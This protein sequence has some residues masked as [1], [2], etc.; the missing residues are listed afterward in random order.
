MLILRQ[1]KC[2]YFAT[3]VAIITMRGPVWHLSML[4][5]TVDE[6]KK[7]KTTINAYPLTFRVSALDTIGH[8]V[9][10]QARGGGGANQL[11]IP[12]TVRLMLSQGWLSLYR[13]KHVP[14]RR[15]VFMSVDHWVLVNQKNTITPSRVPT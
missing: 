5:E 11:N 6:C 14:L 9:L 13:G 12:S 8:Q 10:L 2:A 1:Q 4:Y 3:V 7:K 15:S